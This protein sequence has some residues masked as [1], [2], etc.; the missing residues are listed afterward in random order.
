MFF[1]KSISSCPSETPL[2]H[3]QKTKIAT[4]HRRDT[5]DTLPKCHQDTNNH[6][7][8]IQRAARHQQDRHHQ[9]KRHQFPKNLQ[10][11]SPKNCIFLEDNQVTIRILECGRSP[12]FRHISLSSV[13]L[14]RKV[15]IGFA[16]HGYYEVFW[17]CSG[18][19]PAVSWWYWRNGIF[20]ARLSH[21]SIPNW[22]QRK[23]EN[24]LLGLYAGWVICY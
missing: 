12:S 14:V 17:R 21:L 16:P 23:R 3:E 7:N 10:R 2:K 4:E 1:K 18:G 13:L 5:T 9:D 6:R 19:V 24:W 8:I 22:R 11:I 20:L 15:G